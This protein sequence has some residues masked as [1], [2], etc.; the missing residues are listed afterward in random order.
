M[1]K[2]NWTDFKSKKMGDLENGECLEI[3]SDGATKIFAVIN[4]QELMKDKIVALCGLIDASRG[5]Q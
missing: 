2:I 1:K 5:F 3:M 4:P